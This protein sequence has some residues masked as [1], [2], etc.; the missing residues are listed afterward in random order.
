MAYRGEIFSFYS[1]SD[2]STCLHGENTVTAPRKHTRGEHMEVVSFRTLAAPSPLSSTPT[3][4]LLTLE[5]REHGN[6]VAGEQGVGFLSVDG[7]ICSEEGR[8]T[9][10]FDVRKVALDIWQKTGVLLGR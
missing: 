4:L 2:E 10:R 5:R 1:V 8:A 9:S 3:S 6:H 7:Q